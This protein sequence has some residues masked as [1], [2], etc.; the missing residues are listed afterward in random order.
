MKDYATLVSKFIELDPTDYME[1][2]YDLIRYLSG[3]TSQELM[4][5]SPYRQ[6]E[7]VWLQKSPTEVDWDLKEYFS[8]GHYLV[9]PFY[10]VSQKAT[11]DRFDRLSDIAP[12]GFRTS[13][14]YTRHYKYLG[15]TDEA[16]YVIPVESDT[17]F[18]LCINKHDGRF[19]KSVVDDLRAQLPI[20]AKCLKQYWRTVLASGKTHGAQGDEHRLLVA[21]FDRFGTSI[22]TQREHEIVKLLIKGCSTSESADLLNISAQTLVTH[23]RN[24]YE[25]L[26]V[27]SQSQLFALFFHSILSVQDDDFQDPLQV[28]LSSDRGVAFDGDIPKLNS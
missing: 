20:V 19:T 3:C 26:S 6:P 4:T 5:F 11:D 12:R 16:G 7:L 28:Y 24:I 15:I 27:H 18:H 10:L 9:D 8:C 2:L 17:C 14:Y 25:K 21:A 13:E 22:L 1:A 23:R